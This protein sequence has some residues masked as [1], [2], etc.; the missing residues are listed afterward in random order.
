MEAKKMLIIGLG[1]G[2]S[3][4]LRLFKEDENLEIVGVACRS[5]NALGFK[6][7]KALSIPIISDLLGFIK[8]NDDLDVIVNVT[9][10]KELQ[11]SIRENAEENVDIIDGESAKLFWDLV[12]KRKNEKD[13]YHLL[14]KNCEMLSLGKPLQTVFDTIVSGTSRIL[15]INHCEL[16]TLDE[17]GEKIILRASCDSYLK[18]MMDKEKI[19]HYHYGKEDGFTG[20]IFKTGKPLLVNKPSQFTSEIVLTDDQLKE[21]SDNDR[22]YMEEDRKIKWGDKQLRS[23]SSNFVSSFGGVAIRSHEN[24]VIGV[25]R[26]SSHEYF[27]LP[28]SNGK[29]FARLLTSKIIKEM[30]IARAGHYSFDK[31]IKNEDQLS[32]RLKEVGVRDNGLIL[33]LWQY[34]HRKL[35]REDIKTLKE[36]ANVASLALYNEKQMQFNGMLDKLGAIY[37]KDKLFHCIEPTH[38]LKKLFG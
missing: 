9:G 15:G 32:K 2:G 25:I 19:G 8:E 37:D 29:L 26:V 1:K 34:S 14:Y 22:I 35:T 5:T 12:E 7:A 27:K 20:W 30:Q 13:K 3:F 17:Y 18:D 6:I 16:F 24:M 31:E 38:K 11:K 21:I 10:D 23:P 4:L 33:H 28:S 36:L